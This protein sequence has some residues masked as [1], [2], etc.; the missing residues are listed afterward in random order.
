M[1]HASLLTDRAVLALGGPGARDFLQSLVT[2]DVAAVTEHNA[3][4]T[5]LLT[6]QGKILFDFFVVLGG[7]DHLLI[8]CAASSSADLFNRLRLYKLRAKVE[9]ALRRDLAV[10]AMWSSDDAFANLPPG[11][12]RDPRHPSLGLRMIGTLDVL[13]RMIDRIP[14]GDHRLHQLALGIPSSG[15]LSSDSIF[16]LDAGLEE[17]HGVSFKK[18]CYIGQEVTARMKHRAT[19]R[20]RFFLAEFSGDPPAPGTAVL[21]EGREVA[22]LATGINGRALA[23]VR[24]DRWAEA[25]A[26]RAPIT[27]NGLEVHL[28]KPGWLHD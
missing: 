2:N 9:I 14:A 5:A 20:R 11:S 12:F 18:G 6:P 19:A 16:A 25:T 17:L 27:A 15:D 23:L 28:K 24:L 3:V 4:Y 21:S 26:N 13:A 1:I 8:D 7:N 10:A 22:S